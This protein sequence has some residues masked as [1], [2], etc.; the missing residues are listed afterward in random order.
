[1]I[2]RSLMEEF[3]Y[4][5][6]L[7]IRIPV[8]HVLRV[9][10]EIEIFLLSHPRKCMAALACVFLG[11]GGGAFALA[12]LGPDAALLPVQMVTTPVETL[13][14]TDQAAALDLH[15]LKLF[16]SEVT[17]TSDTP[18][19]LLRRLAIVDP[20]A[21]SFIRKNAMAK[22]GLGRAGRNVS[23]QAN[24]RQQLLSLTTRWLRSE[25]DSVFQRLTIR[26]GAQGFTATHETAPL[27]A[28]L[29]YSGAVVSTSL[30]AAADEA[31]IPDS[32]TSQL[33]DM[34]SA[35][36]DFHRSL[37]NGSR[38]SVVYEAL[39]ADGEPLRT[40]KVLSAEMVN[41]G[42]SY[43][44]MWYQEPGQK[45]EYVSLDG[46]SL[47]NTF[48]AAPVR[49]SRMSSGFGMRLHPLF[50]TARPHLG[51]DY[52]APTGTPALSVADGVVE[53]AGVQ[54]GY[55]NVV[56][57]KH[58]ASQ[59][60]FYAHL[61]QIHVSK[62]KTVKQ[63][64]A[65]GSVGSTGWATGPH[66]HFEFRINGQ[67]VDPLTL[68]KQNTGPSAVASRPGFQKMAALA[69]TQLAFAGQMRES[70]VQ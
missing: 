15:E 44:A 17:R 42:K 63:G 67:H 41:A 4:S 57:V 18:E 3:V 20:E 31:R 58:S 23:A 70:N 43:Q 38:F 2:P 36:I 59:S 60:T 62:G 9:L 56:I 33:S 69:R 68:A 11:G 51:V 53:F 39:E 30:F 24:D 37:R 12:N 28:N 45:G 21:V 65:V 49:F 27:V 8:L 66:L 48:L 22:D 29:Q 26:R 47:K 16:R 40:G 10:G 19:S 61:N 35:Q 13:Q 32:V 55:G 7:K 6:P 52:A 46:K 64:E 34:F 1:L 25:N 14:L 54:S 5:L 50:G